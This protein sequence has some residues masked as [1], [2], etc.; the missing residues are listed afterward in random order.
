M[1]D[2]AITQIEADLEEIQNTDRGGFI[3]QEDKERLYTLESN[4]NK[5]LEEREEVLR[6]KTRAICMECGDDNTKFF[7]AFA[8]GRKQQNTFWELRNANNEIVSSFEDLVETR[9][10]Y[11]ENLFKEDWQATIAAVM[12]IS[13]FFP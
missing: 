6:L 10:S 7:Q 8:K 3:T 4:R 1:D 5:I 9:K 2:Q 13:Q 12:Q 11:F